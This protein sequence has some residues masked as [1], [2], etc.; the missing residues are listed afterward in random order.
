MTQF[1]KFLQVLVF[2]LNFY[3]PAFLS[4]DEFFY[5]SWRNLLN[6]VT[7]KIYRITGLQGLKWTQCFFLNFHKCNYFTYKVSLRVK[8]WKQRRKW[9]KKCYR[10]L[11]LE[12]TTRDILWH[13]RKFKDFPLL[14]S[15]SEPL[16]LFLA[17]GCGVSNFIN[18]N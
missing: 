1:R 6:W 4:W 15:P 2:V 12:S 7:I 13:S 16:W 18:R 17:T 3:S 11:Q 5:I 8:S 9:R 10:N 14:P